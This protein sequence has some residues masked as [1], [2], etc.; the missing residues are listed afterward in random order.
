MTAQQQKFLFKQDQLTDQEYSNN[1][2]L[3]AISALENLAFFYGFP[4]EKIF[5]YYSGNAKNDETQLVNS[6]I[7]Q[8]HLFRAS[9]SNY[10][11]VYNTYNFPKNLTQEK[12]INIIKEWKQFISQKNKNAVIFYDEMLKYLIG[13]SKNS[14]ISNIIDEKMKEWKPTSESDLQRIARITPFLNN[15]VHSKS[16]NIKDIY[17]KTGNY[18]IMAN[19]G[20]KKEDNIFM[21]NLNKIE[22]DYNQRLQQFKIVE[23]KIEAF[24]SEIWKKIENETMKEEDANYILQLTRQFQNL[25]IEVSFEEQE[26]QTK[27]SK[28]QEFKKFIIQNKNKYIVKLFNDV[29]NTIISC[30]QSKSDN[31]FN[32]L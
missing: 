13:D 28:Y 18:E 5:E 1:I 29:C 25:I 3:N 10:Y 27:A 4:G 19:L 14:G 26:I 32:N 23:N 17:N 12:I 21:N 20:R 22:N 15:N 8:L 6:I 16:E 2:M 11:K 24:F 31:Y 7:I 9:H 30:Y